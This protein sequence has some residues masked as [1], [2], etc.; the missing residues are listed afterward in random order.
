M[1]RYLFRRFILIF[2]ISNFVTFNGF[3]I[4]K[5]LPI[6]NNESLET[7]IEKIGQTEEDSIIEENDKEDATEDIIID[8]STIE[9]AYLNDD[10]NISPENNADTIFYQDILNKTID[11][12]ILN[13]IARPLDKAALFLALKHE[14]P[15]VMNEYVDKQIDYLSVK[16]REF[17]VKS[18]KRAE[19]FI[20]EMKEVFKKAGIP[21]DLAY[22]PLIESGYNN[23]AI[24]RRGASGMWQFMPKTA[25]WIGMDVDSFVDERRDPIIACEYAAKFLN[26]LYKS[27]GDWYLVLASYNHGGANISKEI[28]KAGSSNYYDLVKKKVTPTETRNYVPRFI[29]SLAIIK[30][31]E[32]FDID[33]KEEQSKFIYFQLPL[34]TPAHLVA[35]HSSMTYDEFIKLN[36]ALK[37][38]FI[39]DKSYKY[40]IRLPEENYNTLMANMDSLKKDSNLTY[41]PYFIKKG[42]TLSGI[43]TRYGISI[44]VLLSAN[45]LNSKSLLSIGQRLFI[46]VRGY[47]ANSN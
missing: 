4:Q 5:E 38:G 20:L 15:L 27:T 3:A 29:A 1:E 21:E 6:K 14:F 25:K 17:L 23:F 47:Q 41:M 28:K 35:K 2:I 13:M 19:P 44:S 9:K 8:S 30:N 18:L 36:P 22:L 10:K 12:T 46:P 34:T 11:K 43:S 16:K 31:I 24:S 33:Y 37:A 39:P 40:N 7:D 26:F 45:N 42:D 32:N